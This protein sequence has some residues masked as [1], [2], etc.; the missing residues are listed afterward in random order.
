MAPRKKYGVYSTAV[1]IIFFSVVV[2]YTGFVVATTG[3]LFIMLR[4][5]Y[6]WYTALAA[7]LIASIILLFCFQTL[8]GIKL[9]VND[10]GW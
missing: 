8:L 1:G 6:K 5:D 4:R 7:G 2:P 9:P 10:F 3:L